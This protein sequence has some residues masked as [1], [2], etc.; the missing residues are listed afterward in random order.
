MSAT[1]PPQTADL[2]QRAGV[3]Q[4]ECLFPDIT[5]Y[6]RGKLMPLAAFLGGQE[7]RIAQAIPMQAVTGEYSYDPIFPDDDPDVRLVPDLG[8]AR[9]APWAPAGQPR[10]LAIHDCVELDG[11]LCAFAPRSLLKNVLAR[12]EERGLRAVVAPEI[13]F[14]LCAP[15]T[16]ASEPLKAPLGRLGRAEVGQSA[17][18]L[19]MLNELAPFWGAFQQAIETLGIRADTWIHEVG[20]SQY[21]INLWHDDPLAVA[22]QAFLFKHAAR[23]IAIQHG[24]NAVFLAKPMAGEAGSS[25]H[26]HVSVV[27]REGGNIFSAAEGAE[28]PRFR[29]FIGGLQTHLPDLMLLLAPHV[30]SYRRFVKGS[31]APINLLWGYDNRTAGLRVPESGPAARR[32]E[33]RVAGADA[34]P[35]LAIAATLAAGLAGLDEAATPTEPIRGD[36]YAQAHALPRSPREA[37]ARLAAS[38][39]ARRLLGDEFVTAFLSVKEIEFDHHD[40]EISAWER[41]YLLPQV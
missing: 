28:H 39:H 38:P 36:S 10:A 23:E 24:M 37:W 34:N 5:G 2:L 25:M 15:S 3:R 6:P 26:L 33:Q 30:N 17:F 32:I 22:D 31:Q 18:S 21:E 11:R 16:D 4:V 40:Q 7:L 8:T 1:L 12:Y 19:N 35:Y 14:Y 27:D 9:L 13:E 41:R 20:C 29:Q